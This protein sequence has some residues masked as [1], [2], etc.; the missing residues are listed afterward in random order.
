[1]EKVRLAAA[2]IAAACALPLAAAPRMAWEEAAPAKDW[3][4]SSLTGSGIVGAMVEGRLEDETIHL[5]HCKLYL[6]NP[7]DA[8]PLLGTEHSR[9]HQA[10]A[11]RRGEVEYRARD[12]FMAACDLKIAARLG[13]ATAYSRRTDFE[14]G[15][16]I[17][18]ATDDKGRKYSRRVVAPRGTNIVAVRIDDEGARDPSI[19]LCDVAPRSVGDAKAFEGGVKEIVSRP[20][21]YRCEFANSNPWNPLLGYEVLLLVSRKGKGT[22][23]AFVAVEPLE[24]DAAYSRDEAMARLAA[25]A[26]EGYGAIAERNARRMGEIM[27]RVA[28]ELEGPREAD[29]IVRNFNAGRYNIVSS[30]FGDHVPNLQGLWAGTWSAPW[31]AS[32]TVNGNLPCAISFFNRGNTPELNECLLA[33]LQARLPAMREAARLHF[34]ARGFR[35]AAQTTV[36]GVETDSNAGYPHVYWHGGAAWL[37]SRLYDGYRHTLD[38]RWLERIYPLMKELAGY[39]EDVL[40]EMEDGSLGFNPSYSPE[41]WPKGM[42]PTCVNATMDNAIAK[43]FL[44]DAIAAASALGVDEDGRSAWAELRRRLSPYKVSDGGFFAEWLAPG[45]PDNNEHRHASHLYALYDNSPAEILTNAA[46]VAAVAK[47]IDARMDFNENRSRT[48]AFGYVQNGL[49]ACKIGDAGRA[50][51]CLALL[52]AKNW[53]KGGGSCHD[54]KSCFNMD[55]SGGYPYLVSEMLVQSEDS[56]VRFLPAKPA[57]WRKGSIAGLLLRGGIVLE[58]LA[59]RGEDFVAALRFPSGRV[60][61]VAGKSGDAFDTARLAAE[62]AAAAPDPSRHCGIYQWSLEVEG[63]VAKETKAPPRAYL[64]IPPAAKRVDGVVLGNDNML[65]EPIFADAA[66]RAALA[67]ANLAL[68]LVYPGLQG[69]NESFSRGD[70]KVVEDLLARFAS[71]S[72]YAELATA[73]VAPFGHSAWADF[74]YFFASAMPERTLAAISLKGSWPDRKP[75]KDD[76]K[77]M[78]HGI[79]T[80]LVS[81]EYEGAADNLRHAKQ[82]F[83]TLADEPFSFYTDVGSGH[84]EYSSGL[85]DFLGRFLE[86]AAAHGDTKA[87][88][89]AESAKAPPKGKV[90]VIAYLADGRPVEQNPKYHLQIT[91]PSPTGRVFDVAVA[92]DGK[93]PHG[94]PERW[95]GLKAGETPPAPSD[96]SRIVVRNIQGNCEALGGNRFMVEYN[97]RGLPGY[98]AREIV[99]AAEYPADGVFQR[100]TQQAIMRFSRPK[101]SDGQTHWYVREGPAAVDAQGNLV[102]QPLPPR[103]A[104]APVTVCAWQW[105]EVEPLFITFPHA[106]R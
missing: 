86:C 91:L 20:G 70:A 90:G 44:D 46:L 41:N 30:T 100:F 50:E 21:L 83:D 43:Q 60:K 13:K 98:R 75:Y 38:R 81:G 56:R 48:M 88:V 37:L 95:T 39:Y 24:K 96:P 67:R 89:A 53:L 45:Q 82:L 27:R 59:W 62:L 10:G 19:I 12:G 92:F 84:F 36:A 11:G 17:V 3:Q 28:F 42:R 5:S 63:L 2:A 72:G 65:E 23:E 55:V 77:R 64:W 105:G 106:R 7:G 61:L 26:E 76:F 79:P 40:V 47:T 74:P 15:E 93:V 8:A 54:W 14:T 99:F 33:W 71:A 87:L 68:V 58:R 102:P 66:F 78:V 6:P 103:A 104:S 29:E 94:R 25:A 35:A 22:T 4:E 85:P 101:K 9:R 16:C 97:R 31:F 34:G 18:E 1:M 51:R 69:F 73:P 49:A 80:L 32:F 57:S 52:T